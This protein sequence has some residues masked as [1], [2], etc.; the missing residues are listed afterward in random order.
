MKDFFKSIKFKIIVGLLAFLIGVMLFAV[1]K[2]GYAVTGKSLIN[3]LTSPLRNSSNAISV[4]VENY[5]DKIHNA[6]EYYNENQ[7]LKDEIGILNK[8]LSDYEQI[9]SEL[10]EMKQFIGITEENPDNIISE[11]CKITGY[12][13]NDP[14]QSFTI[15]RG[16]EIGIEPYCPVVTSQGLIGITIDVSAD[17]STVRTILSPDLSVAVVCPETLDSAILE[18]YINDEGK[19]LCHLIHLSRDTTFKAGDKLVTKGTGGLFPSGYPVGT[20]T[21][22]IPSENGLSYTAEVEPSVDFEHLSSVVII[23][24]FAGKENQNEN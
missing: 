15:N 16:S 6:T 20:I 24:D 22:V 23:K 7:R 5:L 19:S 10:N 13:A 3:T 1:M 9:K 21:E 2:G 4:K 11:P 17:T 12:I 14:F 18:G 8:K